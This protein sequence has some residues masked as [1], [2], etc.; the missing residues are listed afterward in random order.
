MREAVAYSFA[1]DCHIVTLVRR[2]IFYR[3][4]NRFRNHHFCEEKDFVSM[5]GYYFI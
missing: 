2:D 4:Q 1:R 5:I 3:L